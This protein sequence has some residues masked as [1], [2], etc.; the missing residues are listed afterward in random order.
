[1]WV[2]ICSPRSESVDV[3][4]IVILLGAVLALIGLLLRSEVLTVVGVVMILVGF[5]V[6]RT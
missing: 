3:E 6:G 2:R 1:M 5:F 4:R